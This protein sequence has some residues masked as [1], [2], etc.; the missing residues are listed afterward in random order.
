MKN[1]VYTL[2][3]FISLNLESASK[4]KYHKTIIR[5]P[6]LFIYLFITICVYSNDTALLEDAVATK[7]SYDFML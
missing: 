2:P 1:S 5:C 4:I 3:V 7:C 6:Y